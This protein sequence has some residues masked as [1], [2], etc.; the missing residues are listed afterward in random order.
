MKVKGWLKCQEDMAVSVLHSGSHAAGNWR[1]LFFLPDACHLLIMSLGEVEESEQ[2]STLSSLAF[3]TKP[4]PH[5]HV[6]D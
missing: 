5:R 3:L 1:G 4:R 6:A 2:T